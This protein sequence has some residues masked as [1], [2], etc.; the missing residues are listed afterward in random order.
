[1]PTLLLAEGH[2]EQLL[3]PPLVRFKQDL[4]GSFQIL[5]PNAFLHVVV[6]HVPNPNPKQTSAA[7]GRTSKSSAGF[8]PMLRSGGPS[9]KQSES[10]VGAC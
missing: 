3:V 4:A 10:G 2:F 5:G 1:L 6:S 7:I 8:H 9:L